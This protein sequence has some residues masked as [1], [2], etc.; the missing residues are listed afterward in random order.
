MVERH[1]GSQT[2]E[3]E[4]VADE[5]VQREIPPT[6]RPARLLHFAMTRQ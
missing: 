3:V 1:G 2:V 6:N 5:D 4:D